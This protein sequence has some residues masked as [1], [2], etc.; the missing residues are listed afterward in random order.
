MR[1]E[2]RLQRSHPRGVEREVSSSPAV[3]GQWAL[4][5]SGVVWHNRQLART[6]DYLLPDGRWIV[7]DEREGTQRV[8]RIDPALLPSERDIARI[9]DIGREIARLLEQ[10]SAWDGFTQLSPV[11]R[12]LDERARLQR[13]ERDLERGLGPL[14]HVCKRPRLH[15]HSSGS[16]S[17]RHG[18]DAFPAGRQ[19]PRCP[20][21]GLGGPHGAGRP[22][23]AVAGHRHRGSV[24]SLP[25]RICGIS[26]RTA[27]PSGWWITCCAT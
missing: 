15:L 6:L 14:K 9:L 8:G 1:H 27:W 16:G 20:L 26:T 7:Q 11:M 18:P 17:Q 12:N 2:L 13:L 19:L 21:R 3:P 22:P 24:G 4:E 23:Q 10:P 5:T 25:P